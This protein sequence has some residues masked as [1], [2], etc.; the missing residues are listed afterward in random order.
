MNCQSCNT[1]IDYRFVTNCEGC[2]CAVETDGLL[3]PNSLPDIQP[4]ESAKKIGSWKREIVNLTYVLVSSVAGM[5]SGAVIVYVGAA[6]VY[7]AVY[8]G[9]DENPS[10]ACARGM[11]IGFLS[12]VVGAFL[13]TVGGSMMAVK[14]P[15]CK[16]RW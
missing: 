4:F 13:G 11:A 7:S 2:G 8:S 10:V 3:K 16:P 9:V 6:L 5:I 1:R 15:L 14:R 12:I